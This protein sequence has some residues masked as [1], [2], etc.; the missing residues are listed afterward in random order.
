MIN[1]IKPIP[2][3]VRRQSLEDGSECKIDKEME[4]MAEKLRFMKYLLISVNLSIRNCTKGKK[5][6]MF[7][8]IIT[9]KFPELM[10]NTT[11]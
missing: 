10:E 11:H 5:K 3:Q 7:Q 4:N 9:K 8:Q 1:Q 6:T 2:K